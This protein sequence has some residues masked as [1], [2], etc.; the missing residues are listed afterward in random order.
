MILVSRLLN[1]NKQTMNKL[2]PDAPAMP[3]MWDARHRP[4]FQTDG[5]L[6][7]RQEL[8]ARFM[9]AM[10]SADLFGSYPD[11]AS[12]AFAAADSFISV[13]NRSPVKTDDP[14]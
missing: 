4:E 5:G 13:G 14:A 10:I 2:N 8:A 7:I 1:H 11:I 9:A 12:N 6:T 3:F